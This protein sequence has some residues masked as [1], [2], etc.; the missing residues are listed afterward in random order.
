MV[1]SPVVSKSCVF[2]LPQLQLYFNFP[3]QAT[4]KKSSIA[5]L[6]LGKGPAMVC[7]K[8][9]VIISYYIIYGWLTYFHL[10]TTKSE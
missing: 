3:D 4:V 9:E 10:N 2:F 8:P 1:S 6:G 5:Y 7:H